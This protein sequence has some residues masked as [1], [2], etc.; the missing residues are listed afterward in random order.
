[1]VKLLCSTA[2]VVAVLGAWSS[3]TFANSCSS[4][5]CVEY[6][7]P[8]PSGTPIVND[9]P[10]LPA[11]GTANFM[12]AATVANTLT[13]PDRFE[14]TLSDST[15]FDV[16]ANDQAKA[17]NHFAAMTLRFLDSGGIPIAGDSVSGTNVRVL[18]LDGITLAAGTYFVE[19]LYKGGTGL[20]YHGT[21]DASSTGGSPTPIPA[22]LPLFAGGV[23]LL[24]FGLRKRRK[25]GRNV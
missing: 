3:P 8:P 13:T 10:T 18:D 20:S 14:F 17:G 21:I 19:V 25:A 5:S 1:V 15:T 2:A 7:T 12:N 6:I 24:G 23:G 22:A 16:N 9:D 11:D 4:T